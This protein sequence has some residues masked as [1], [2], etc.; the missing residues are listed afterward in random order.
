M[1]YVYLR[2]TDTGRLAVFTALF[3]LSETDAR[4]QAKD[5]REFSAKAWVISRVEKRAT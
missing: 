1:F 3:A 4:Q 5:A 2:N